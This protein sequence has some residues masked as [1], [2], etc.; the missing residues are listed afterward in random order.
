MTHPHPPST[1][2][3]PRPIWVLRR[4]KAF[5][6]KSKPENALGRERPGPSNVSASLRIRMTT[7]ST[8]HVWAREWRWPKCASVAKTPEP[9]LEHRSSSADPASSAAWPP[10]RRPTP[11]RGDPVLGGSRHDGRPDQRGGCA[12]QAVEP[13]PQLRASSSAM[14]H[15]PFQMTNRPTGRSFPEGRL[16]PA[17]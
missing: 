5:S 6:G 12:E 17:G 15:P 9:A 13:G 10:G 1:M 3:Q 11:C 2:R 4:Q 8:M 16:W 7:R 14:R